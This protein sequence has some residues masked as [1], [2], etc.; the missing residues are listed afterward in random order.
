MA[1]R[2]EQISRAGGK[3]N[4]NENLDF[5]EIELGQN[6]KGYWYCKSLKVTNSKILVLKTEI[7]ELIGEIE[8]IIKTY[9]LKTDITEEKDK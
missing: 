5:Y 2:L 4:M 7:E 8:E 1:R 6:S 9:N 3:S